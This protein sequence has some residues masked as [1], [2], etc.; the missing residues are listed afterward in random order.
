MVRVTT[1]GMQKKLDD[2]AKMNA[3]T[4]QRITRGMKRKMDGATM[5][6]ALNHLGD[7]TINTNSSDSKN[8]NFVPLPNNKRRKI[9]DDKKSHTVSLPKSKKKPTNKND[10]PK[11]VNSL[12]QPFRKYDLVWAR[13]RGFCHWPGVVENILNDGKY[14]IHF[15]GDYSYSNVTR[16]NIVNYFD[17]FNEF[18]CNYGNNNLRKAVKEATLFLFDKN[19]GNECFVCKMLNYKK[20]LYCNE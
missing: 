17:G 15:F 7:G 12:M 10:R 8:V 4:T 11:P 6:D 5:K 14:R 20:Q 2:E 1:R 13:V 3:I 16:K 19:T 9:T 18:A